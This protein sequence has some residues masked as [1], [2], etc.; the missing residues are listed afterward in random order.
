MTPPRGRALA[1]TP[2]PTTRLTRVLDGEVRL[3]L[4]GGGQLVHAQRQ[5]PLEGGGLLAERREAS[6]GALPGDDV[7]RGVPARD[8]LGSQG[9][10]GG[11]RGRRGGR[12]ASRLVRRRARPAAGGVSAHTELRLYCRRERQ[13]ARLSFNQARPQPLTQ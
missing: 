5:L 6:E 9:G 13:T 4:H 3:A 10:H 1:E 7:G 12:G 11:R 8:H 2:P